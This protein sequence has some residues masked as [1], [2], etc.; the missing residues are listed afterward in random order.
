LLSGQR[1]VPR[2][3]LRAGFAFRLPRLADALADLY[4]EGGARR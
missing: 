4:G 1:V 3:L 2:E